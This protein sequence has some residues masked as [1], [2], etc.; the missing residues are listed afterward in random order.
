M[1]SRTGGKLMPE[2]VVEQALF[3]DQGGYRFLARSSGFR[4]DWLAEAEQLCK[5]FG[6]RPSGVSCPPCVFAR[7]FGR[8]FVAVV[9]AADQGRHDAGGL[10]WLAFHLLLLL[11]SDYE[12]LG[13]DPFALVERCAPDWQVRGEL[14]ALTWPAEVLPARTVEQVRRVLQRPEGPNLLGASQILVDGGRVAFERLAAETELIRDLWTLLPTR[15]RSELWPASFAF[16]NALR[17]DALVVPPGVREKTPADFPHYATEE[18]AGDYP[19][20]RYELNLQTAA[21]AGSQADLDALFARRSRSEMWR[22]GLVILL[23]ALVLPLLVSWLA[24]APEKARPA[25]TSG[26]PSQRS[27]PTPRAS[28]SAQ[29]AVGEKP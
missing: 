10:R 1:S 20:G 7:P 18:E 22:L 5:G 9:Q 3:G 24:P 27:G 29:D 2:I 23:I 14:P 12:C 28:G 16:G 11:R 4:E 15:T 19:E 21:E 13:G 25:P 6:E 26:V 8:Q 17:F